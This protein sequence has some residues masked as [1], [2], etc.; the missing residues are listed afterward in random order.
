MGIS[1]KRNCVG[2]RSLLCYLA[3]VILDTWVSISC[4]KIKFLPVSMSASSNNIWACC[5]SFLIVLTRDQ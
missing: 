1:L 4:H 2:L 3:L 5:Q